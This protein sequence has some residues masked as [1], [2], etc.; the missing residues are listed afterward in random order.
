M[1]QVNGEDLV[2]AS[3]RRRRDVPQPPGEVD[4]VY[5]LVFE[6]ASIGIWHFD[7]RGVITACNERFAAILG[8]PQRV[9][10]GLDMLSLPDQR[11]VDCVK[12][13]LAGEP[14][15]FEGEYRSATSGKTSPAHVDF[16]PIFVTG[17]DGS[18]GVLGGVGL[19]EDINERAAALAALQRSEAAFRTLI[20]N[21]PDAVAVYREDGRF[22]YVNP[23]LVRLLGYDQPEELLGRAVTEVMHPDERR[24]FRRAGFAA[25]VRD[26][27]SIREG[28]FLRKDGKLVLAEVESR[29][30]HFDGGEAIIVLGRDITERKQLQQRLAQ[31]DRMASVGTLAAGIAHEI[32]NPLAYVVASIDLANRKLDM[33]KSGRANAE[34]MLTQVAASLANA[35][36]G[37]ERVSTIV[38]D[39]RTFSRADPNRRVPVDVE[40]VIDSAV[41]MAWN[42]VGKKAR[43]VKDYGGV[44]A[45]LGDE[46]RLGQVFLNLLI[47]AT[48]AIDGDP[49]AQR[50]ARHHARSGGGPRDRRDRRHRARHCA[51]AD[52]AHLRAVRHH[53]A[54][55]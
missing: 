43:L 41:N 54:D 50:G 23:A 16:T 22:I 51:R 45:V 39:L 12:R 10:V 14:A 26:N 19:A 47:N 18:R 46:A 9:L 36:E 21:A 27:E 2:V 30:I 34:S 15:R 53:Q 5:R 37:A 20:E 3:L 8:S 31:A 49:Q 13:A 17:A 24:E 48:H 4:P 33:V 7:A 44:S 28:R 38:R 29:P 40:R 1:V 55:R 35:R 6:N 52:R 42:E 32:N 11:I 25:I